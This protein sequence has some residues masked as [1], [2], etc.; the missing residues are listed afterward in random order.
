[1]TALLRFLT[2]ACIFVTAVGVAE[3]TLIFAT[4]FDLK[5]TVGGETSE[6]QNRVK[7]RNGSTIPIE[8]QRHRVDVAIAEASAD[9]FRANLRIYEKTEGEWYLLNAASLSFVGSYGSP[10]AYEWNIG[11]ISLDLAIVVSIANQ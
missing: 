6:A 2:I 11:E 9:E 7:V 10:T 3:S 1:M 4:N 5:L 8:F